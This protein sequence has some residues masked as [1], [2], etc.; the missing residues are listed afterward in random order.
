M[1]V[2]HHII[3]G[4]YGFWLPNDPRGRWSDF[5]RSWDLYRDRSAPGRTIVPVA[6]AA[7]TTEK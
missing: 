1:I 3:I 6:L 5:V 4:M 2:G 7:I